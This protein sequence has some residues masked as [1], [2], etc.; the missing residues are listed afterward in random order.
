VFAG[1][2]VVGRSALLPREHGGGFVFAE[3]GEHRA[4]ACDQKLDI[5]I[6]LCDAR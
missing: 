4:E 1:D 2:G 6:N 3:R 5:G